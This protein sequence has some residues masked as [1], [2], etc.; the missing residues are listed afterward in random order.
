[1]TD[2]QFALLVVAA[3]AAITLL[4]CIFDNDDWNP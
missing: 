4:V 1:M 3:I 2:F